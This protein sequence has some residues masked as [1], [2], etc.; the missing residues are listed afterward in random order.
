MKLSTRLCV[1]LNVSS[2]TSA[3]YVHIYGDSKFTYC[4]YRRNSY[5]TYDAR[6]IPSIVLL[7]CVLSRA[8]LSSCLHDVDILYISILDVSCSLRVA[9]SALTTAPSHISV[10]LYL[11][12]CR[13]ALAWYLIKVYLLKL[14]LFIYL[15][16][17][18][19]CY[20]GLFFI[21]WTICMSDNLVLYWS[22]DFTVSVAEHRNSF[23]QWIFTC[24]LLFF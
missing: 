23:T 11:C 16:I 18:S 7:G 21:C 17:Y 3:P 5:W 14:Y 22:G 9:P 19:A 4:R 8:V 6:H 15:F 20:G 10:S 24:V 2:F 13:G 12:G 1:V